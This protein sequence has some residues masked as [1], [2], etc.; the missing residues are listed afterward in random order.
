[1]ADE[2]L[3]TQE[4]MEACGLQADQVQVL[5]KCFD[6]FADEDGAIPAEQVWTF[7][8]LLLLASTAPTTN[9]AST[10]IS[11]PSLSTH[12]PPAPPLNSRLAV[13]WP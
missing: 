4:E 3:L 1:M 6:G 2:E 5:K 10:L 9:P 11:A 12:P 13:S 7:L 8:L